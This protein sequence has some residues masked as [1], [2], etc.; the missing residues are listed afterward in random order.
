MVTKLTLGSAFGF[1]D[2]KDVYGLIKGVKRLG[3]YAE[4]VSQMPWLHKI[5]QDN[6]LLRR[7]RPS[8]FVGVVKQAVQDRIRHPDPEDQPRPDLLSHFVA[9]HAEYPSL[10]DPQQVA[11]FASGNMAAGGLSPGKTFDNLC[12]YLATHPESQDRL[13]AEIQ[14]AQCPS[15][16]P[17]SYDQ[18]RSLPYLEGTI[19]E[20]FRFN[21]AA[22]TNLQR[23]TG[24][25]GLTLPNGC[26]VPPNTNIGC[27]G[28]AINQD[29]RVFG[30]DADLFRPERW[31]QGEAET[32]EAYLDRRRVM[33]KS[34]MTFGHG[35]RS[36]IGRNIAALE[37]FK[38]V[39]TLMAQFKVRSPS[40]SDRS[41]SRG[42][43][44]LH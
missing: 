5:F 20:G 26:H 21:N 13:N 27:P 10:M 7:T 37:F 19:R 1:L 41:V 4:L 9:T 15:S 8:L 23:V 31:M 40:Q 42:V 18:A 35:S 14:A 12:R 3:F 34:D 38:A 44:L 29:P 22:V 39:A 2:D 32:H 16:S 36:C 11:I 17:V 25:G 6:P 43:E 24:E 33:E 28:S 30:A